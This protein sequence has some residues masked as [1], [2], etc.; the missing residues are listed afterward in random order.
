MILIGLL[1]TTKNRPGHDNYITFK[2]VSEMCKKEIFS[3]QWLIVH[4]LKFA[5]QYNVR[6]SS[7]WKQVRLYWTP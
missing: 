5:F 1:L 6:T 7:H 2:N 4:K 3:V